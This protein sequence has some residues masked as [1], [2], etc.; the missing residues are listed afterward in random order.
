MIRVRIALLWDSRT[1]EMSTLPA[2]L[3]GSLTGTGNF[4]GDVSLDFPGSFT[5]AAV[6]E[7]M[8]RLPDFAP[9]SAKVTLTLDS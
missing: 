6:E 2:F 4:S 3:R 8:E 9:G 1:V 7:M 5:K